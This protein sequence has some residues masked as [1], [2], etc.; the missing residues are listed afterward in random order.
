MSGTIPQ[1]AGKRQ[2]RAQL[3]RLA[4]RF[5][6]RTGARVFPVGNHW[7]E[8]LPD[9]MSGKTPQACKWKTE[10]A[11]DAEG[12]ARLFRRLLDERTDGPLPYRTATGYGVAMGETLAAVDVDDAD[13]AA[14]H[15][16]A[17]GPWPDT[18]EVVT[19]SGGWHWVYEVDPADGPAQG[20]WGKDGYGIDLR[21][22]K[23]DGT[24][25]GFIVGPGSWSDKYGRCWIA[26]TRTPPAPDGGAVARL[27]A[28]L[29]RLR[30]EANPGQTFGP[31]AH[32]GAV[33]GFGGETLAADLLAAAPA[34]QWAARWAPAW[35]G[36]PDGAGWWR[37][38][39]GCQTKR[40]TPGL[41]V[42]TATGAWK[43]W[44]TE[45]G[46]GL[47]A[48][49]V[50][51]GAHPDIATAYRELRAEIGPSSAPS[52]RLDDDAYA[53]RIAKAKAADRYALDVSRR[54]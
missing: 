47:V 25:G 45:Q 50:H 39:C 21:G 46:G 27:S 51:L 52:D 15:L 54:R 37:G 1:K 43:C 30:A 34:E 40:Q 14:E 11:A 16:D 5:S 23:E 10:A 18:L 7:D 38:F 48:L 53:D 3:V 22:A 19:P 24:V 6:E 33:R 35:G 36:K 20:G 8:D 29:R 32:T 12:I 17:C 44:S 26:A 9:W 4:S 13:A 41:V 42:D 28:R 2:T 31:Q 49:A